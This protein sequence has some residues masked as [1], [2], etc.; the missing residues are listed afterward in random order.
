MVCFGLSVS[1]G[2]WK[3]EL[4][5]APVAAQR[6]VPP[7]RRDVDAVE[8]DLPGGLASEL[9]D[10]APGRRLARARLPDQRQ[11]LAALDVEV[12]PVDR[13][14]GTGRPPPERV[15]EAAADREM[16]LQPL[17]LDQRTGRGACTG[18][19]RGV[20]RRAAGGRRL[21]QGVRHAVAA[22]VVDTTGI[23]GTPGVRTRAATSSALMRT[24]PP[25]RAGRGGTRRGRRQETRPRAGRP[26]GRPPSRPDS[27]GGTGI[28]AADHAGPAATR[29]SC[30]GSAGRPGCSGT[31]RAAS[32]CRD[33][34]E[35]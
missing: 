5:P 30:R 15:D 21:G 33:G 27:A 34:A 24:R 11:H 35:P 16:D 14:H 28:P 17:E 31:P 26:R 19:G 8:G 22:G 9:D 25:G 13:A 32:A 3:I 12:D 6:L 1:Y 10:H 20:G 4:D 2:S 18:A 7:Q 29:G 23:S